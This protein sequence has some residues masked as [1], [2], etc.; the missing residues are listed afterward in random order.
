MDEQLIPSQ[1]PVVEPEENLSSEELPQTKVGNRGGWKYFFLGAFISLLM[2]L[3]AAGGYYTA[4][5][6]YHKPTPTPTPL[7]TIPTRIPTPTVIASPSAG[8]TIPTP[9][10]L[11]TKAKNAMTTYLEGFKK[12]TNQDKKLTDYTIEK[13]DLAKETKQG[14]TFHVVYSVLPANIQFSV[15]QEGN[16][17]LDTG[18]WVRNKSGTAT[19]TKQ[20]DGSYKIQNIAKE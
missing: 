11:E 14:L 8:I 15:W 20:K 3:S 6:K 9:S 12:S 2:I 17:S 10:P 13:I 19:A 7:Y 18:G 1:P 4:E 5:Q 16:G